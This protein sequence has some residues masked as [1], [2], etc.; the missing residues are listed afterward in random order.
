MSLVMFQRHVMN[1]VCF[2]DPSETL[3]NESQLRFVYIYY[4]YNIIYM[5]KLKEVNE[6]PPRRLLK[7]VYISAGTIN[8]G[9]R[10]D[11]DIM[12]GEQRMGKS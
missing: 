12:T 11:F 2:S 5:A 7:N 10:K 9:K 1:V 8:L 4:I 6:Y 3:T